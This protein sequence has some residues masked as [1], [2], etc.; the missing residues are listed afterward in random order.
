MPTTNANRLSSS[1]VHPPLT[2]VK[3]AAYKKQYQNATPDKHRQKALQCW[4]MAGLARQDRDK[5]DEQRQTQRA[6]WH[7][8]MASL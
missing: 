1:L 7:D 5:K 4:D 2:P 3:D 6:R 8:E